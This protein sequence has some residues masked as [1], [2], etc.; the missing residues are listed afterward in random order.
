MFYFPS[1]IT[2]ILNELI[3]AQGVWPAL[4]A[5]AS[6]SLYAAIFFE[7]KVEAVFSFFILEMLVRRLVQ[8]NQLQVETQQHSHKAE[9]LTYVR[10]DVGH[11]RRS[12]RRKG[13]MR[14]HPAHQRFVASSFPDQP[15]GFC[16][17]KLHR[18]PSRIGSQ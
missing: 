12:S 6:E 3:R 14:R 2:A 4:A 16:Q 11:L 7:L 17:V 9:S 13:R 8:A 15:C 5:Y 10:Y 18:G 1:K